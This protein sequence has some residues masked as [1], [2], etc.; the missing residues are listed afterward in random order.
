MND[1]RLRK[2]EVLY[3]TYDGLL[4]PI[5]QSQILKY[6]VHLS[7]QH[8]FTILSLEKEKRSGRQEQAYRM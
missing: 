1:K 3:I 5:G 2:K 6:V 8:D 7:S 4:E